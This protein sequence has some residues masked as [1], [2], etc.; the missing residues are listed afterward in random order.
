M[1]SS[2][3]RLGPGRIV[4]YNQATV[5]LSAAGVD[6]LRIGTLGARQLRLDWNETFAC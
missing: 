2:Y 4:T 1:N 5:G 3:D 6:Q